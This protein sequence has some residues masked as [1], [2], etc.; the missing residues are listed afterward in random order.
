MN[1]YQ[2]FAFVCALLMTSLLGAENVTEGLSAVQLLEQARG[3]FPHE[4]IEI[5]GTLTV[6]EERGLNTIARPYTLTLDWN[7][8][9]PKAVCTLFLEK[10]STTVVQRATLT[11][12]GNEKSMVTLMNDKGESVSNVRFNTPVGESDVT[13]MDL[14]LD[15]LWWKNARFLTEA[16]V[17]AGD[18]ADHS[19]G[20]RCGSRNCLVIEVQP[21]DPIPGCKAV[22]LWIDESSGYMVQAAQIG[23]SGSLQRKM[24]IQRVGREEGRWVPREFRVKTSAQRR[25]TSLYVRNVR[26]ESFQSEAE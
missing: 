23:S 13:W 18:T 2:R 20:F 9:D 7:G 4:R 21:P 1:G 6:A 25:Q 10:G 24:W 17:R 22:W 3:M 15:Y 12:R 16:E 5:D 8:T 19:L 26:S 14:S 11:R